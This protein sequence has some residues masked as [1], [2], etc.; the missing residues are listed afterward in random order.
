MSA[1]DAEINADAV[2]GH[3]HPSRRSIEPAAV[4]QFTSPGPALRVRHP[5]PRYARPNFSNRVLPEDIALFESKQPVGSSLPSAPSW[6][7]GRTLPYAT[8]SPCPAH[9]RG[10]P[11]IYNHFPVLRL[12][13]ADPV[14]RLSVL[15][16]GRPSVVWAP[17][18]SALCYVTPEEFEQPNTNG[19]CGKAAG[20]AG[21]GPCLTPPLC[22]VSR[23]GPGTS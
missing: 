4:V 8:H 23:G 7:A 15:C 9:L 2:S 21:R 20:G 16:R 13:S 19:A 22:R 6:P 18:L 12:R 1:V 5:G 10:L 3:A 17:A 14:D 11:P